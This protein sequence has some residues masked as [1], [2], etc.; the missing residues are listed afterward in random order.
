MSVNAPEL[1]TKCDDIERQLEDL[2]GRQKIPGTQIC[3]MLPPA[4]PPSLA[5]GVG[6][7]LLQRLAP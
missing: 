2:A 4:T 6:S 5:S 7:S 3:E 1:S